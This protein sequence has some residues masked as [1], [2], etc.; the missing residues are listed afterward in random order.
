M[1][2][3][4]RRDR[5]PS[6][7]QSRWLLPLAVFGSIGV[8]ISGC[9]TIE[10]W[11]FD[12]TPAETA[13]VGIQRTV[14]GYMAITVPCDGQTWATITMTEDSGDSSEPFVIWNES[15]Q[16]GIALH[17]PLTRLDDFMANRP[18]ATVLLFTTSEP[19]SREASG[20]EVTKAELDALELHAI[21]T[22]D[23][24]GFP[25][26]TVQRSQAEFF[27]DAASYCAG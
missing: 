25:F 17:T 10:E 27:N 6:K 11:V 7:G 5:L 12:N 21:V 20:L 24:G 22:F 19:D 2:L 18:P 1:L 13:L 23:V 3:M 8:T 4:P 26:P 15:T 9:S 16:D 14:D